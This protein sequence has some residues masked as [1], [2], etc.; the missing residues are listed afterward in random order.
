MSFPVKSKIEYKVTITVANPSAPES[1][2]AQGRTAIEAAILTAVAAVDGFGDGDTSHL[3]IDASGTR[4]KT[5]T[6]GGYIHVKVESSN[7]AM[8]IATRKIVPQTTGMPA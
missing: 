4:S 7:G 8:D 6:N 2:S 3:H 5:G 1:H